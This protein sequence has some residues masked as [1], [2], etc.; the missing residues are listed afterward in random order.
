MAMLCFAEH[1]AAYPDGRVPMRRN[2]GSCGWRG[3]LRRD[4]KRTMESE[5]E[6]TVNKTTDKVERVEVVAVPE[7][8]LFSKPSPT[9][10]HESLHSSENARQ[11]YVI[12]LLYNPTS[13]V[14][15]RPIFCHKSTQQ[16]TVREE[17]GDLPIRH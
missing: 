6:G 14:A 17:E 11:L 16:V 2:L 3:D 8:H 12:I 15:F 9:S 10:Q 7:Y 1:S 4:W 5:R 13:K